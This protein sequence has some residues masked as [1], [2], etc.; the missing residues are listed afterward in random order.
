[1]EEEYCGGCA[2]YTWEECDGP[3]GSREGSDVYSDTPACDC[4]SEVGSD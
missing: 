4:Y 2:Y 3:S 1:M